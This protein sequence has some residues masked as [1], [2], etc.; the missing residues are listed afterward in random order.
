V[1][2]PRTMRGCSRLAVRL[3]PSKKRQRSLKADV[4]EAGNL[5]KDIRLAFFD[6][7]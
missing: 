2:R 7:Q 1:S 6:T 4:L 5:E 3:K